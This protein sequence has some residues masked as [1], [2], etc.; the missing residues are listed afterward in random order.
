MR[1]MGIGTIFRQAS[2][3]IACAFHGQFFLR[4]RVLSLMTFPES[5]LEWMPILLHY[6]LQFSSSQNPPYGQSEL[7]TFLERRTKHAEP[8][9][10]KIIAIR[11]FYTY[12]HVLL[13][14]IVYRYP[15]VSA[16]DPSSHSDN[17]HR[18]CTAGIRRRFIHHNAY[19]TPNNTTLQYTSPSTP[20]CYDLGS[21]VSAL[22]TFMD[23]FVRTPQAPHTALKRV[24]EEQMASFRFATLNTTLSPHNVANFNSHRPSS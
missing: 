24:R 8:I 10:R 9:F 13:R 3:Y 5:A 20:R 21:S 6:S 4:S 17:Q 22:P 18:L 7:Q 15:E 12:R 11:W 19:L 2:T 23:T 16:Y 14:T 1:E